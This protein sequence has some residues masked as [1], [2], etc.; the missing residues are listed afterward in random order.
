MA[1]QPPLDNT[2]IK[3]CKP[4]ANTCNG[5]PVIDMSDS[6]GTRVVEACEDFGFFKVTNHG[7]SYELMSTLETYAGKFFNMSQAD[8]KRA[9]PPN[10]FGYGNKKIGANGDEGWVEYLLFGT[11]GHKFNMSIVHEDFD[12]FR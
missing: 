3:T 7:V 12:L 5:I 11:K 6:A 4:I 8:K 1:S 9:G 2:F 10:P